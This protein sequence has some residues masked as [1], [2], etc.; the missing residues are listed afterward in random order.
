MI[1]YSTAGESHGR[2]LTAILEGVP[3][4]VP[5]AEE[6]INK[7][8]VRRQHTYGRGERQKY[9]EDDKAAIL[10]GVRWGETLG[11]PITLQV[12]NKDWENWEKI[13]SLSPA[14]RA[15]KFEL[16]RPRPGHAD[17]V[18]ALKF[19]RRDVRDILERASARET[20]V[21]TAVGA[22]CKR[23]LEEAGIKIYSYVHA[24]GRIEAD[25]PDG[26]P[27]EELFAR[28]EA[29]PIR[30]PDK[31]AGEKMM[32]AIDAA[33][34]D[35]DTLG[36]MWT[37]VATG[38]PVGLGSHAQWDLKLDGQLAQAIMSI[39]AHKGFEIG[40]GFGA[41]R[42]R[43]SESHDEIR[44][45]PGRGFFRD[46]NHAGGLE[47]GMTNGEP[48]IIRAAMKPLASLRKP[49][50]SVNLRTKEEMTAEIVRSDVCPIAAAAVIG[51]AV[52]AVVLAD[53]LT[54]KFGG[55]SLRELKDNLSRYVDH[56]KN[57]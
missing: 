2:C 36:G 30:T 37:V 49:L 16:L 51:E 45:A 25:I 48:L 10:S 42:A 14:D 5:I 46:T 7:D 15:E 24:V 54:I 33:K 52:T 56:V 34:A 39:Q 8:L 23:L 22:V 29:S 55:D 44:H 9:I 57:F 43:G 47:G 17:L 12:A 32:A 19:D 18:G 28:A 6:F 40:Q 41:A 20:A 1:R 50:K 11:S 53:A 35:G 38:L 21:R 27:A 31:A 3:A 13:M 26:V 4:G